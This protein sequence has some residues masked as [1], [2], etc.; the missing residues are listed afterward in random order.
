MTATFGVNVVVQAEFEYYAYILRRGVTKC[1]V[2][3]KTNFV[4]LANFLCTLG[5]IRCVFELH[6]VIGVSALPMSSQNQGE[7]VRGAGVEHCGSEYIDLSVCRE[8]W[9]E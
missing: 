1:V 6:A 8:V 4:E 7:V 5:D 2:K 9:I 3:S